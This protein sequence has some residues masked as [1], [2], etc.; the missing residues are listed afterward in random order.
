MLLNNSKGLTVALW[1]L[2]G[3]YCLLC[4]L[5]YLDYGTA[6]PFNGG[7]LIYLNAVWP[8]PD[9]LQ[10]FLFAGFFI[11]LGHTAGNSVAFSR[12][13]L[14]AA[15][16]SS[17]T[18]ELIHYAALTKFVAIVVLGLVCMLLWIWPKAGLFL[19]KVLALYK[20]VLLLVMSF[21]GIAVSLHKDPDHAKYGSF[22]KDWEGHSGGMG[23][24]AGL[25]YIIYSYTGWENANY[26]IGDIKTKK[27]DL[28]NG[29]FG[30]VILVTVLYTLM[31]V[32]F[33]LVCSKAAIEGISPSTTLSLQ[34]RAAVPPTSTATGATPTRSTPP[35]LG[36]AYIFSEIVFGHRRGTEICIAISAVGNL[37]AVAYTSSKVKQ[38][39][40]L[41]HFLP[42]AGFFARDDQFLTPGGALLLHWLCSSIVIV[43][44]PN[45]TDGYN[46]VISLFTY[47]QLPVGIFIGIGLPRLRSAVEKSKKQSPLS[48]MKSAKW[49]PFFSNQTLTWFF[50]PLLAAINLVVMIGAAAPITQTTSEGH[51]IPRYY[52]TIILFSTLTSALVYWWLF[53]RLKGAAGKWLGWKVEL[54]KIEN[55][56][57]M[58]REERRDGTEQY[59]QH[60]LQLVPNEVGRA[61]KVRLRTERAAK[62]AEENL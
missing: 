6:F 8:L 42:F 54:T 40:A 19:N 22:A 47:G 34:A 26:I 15:Q 3:L 51:R 45:T 46:F 30:A 59:F 52:L 35:D 44:M 23:S 50:G 29:A 10:A 24:I 31:S 1:A 28:R 37:V 57:V 61:E 9:L 4:L 56:E 39:I 36:I 18:L 53:T 58:I 55:L 14:L 25:I 12:H 13:V 5:V 49:E 2:G 33:F 48:S 11:S 17:D 20:V 32:S 38:A 43:A 21:A 27:R 60:N 41:H 62:W 16:N 7:E